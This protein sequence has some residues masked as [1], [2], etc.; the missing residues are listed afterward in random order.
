MNKQLHLH[1]L[2]QRLRKLIAADGPN[3]PL[4]VALRRRVEELER[5]IGA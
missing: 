3:S 5:R 2:R 4:V 1:N